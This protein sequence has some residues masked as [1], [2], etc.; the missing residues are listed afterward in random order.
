LLMAIGFLSGCSPTSR[1]VTSDRRYTGGFQAGQTYRLTDNASLILAAADHWQTGDRHYLTRPACADLLQREERPDDKPMATLPPGTRLRITRIIAF[2]TSP[3]PFYWHDL[4]H[5]LA[6]LL[7]GPYGGTEVDI[8]EIS[9]HV[10]ENGLTA[11]IA[12][13][14]PDCLQLEGK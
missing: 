3:T 5:P 1:D 6:T 7:D 13:P 4:I 2:H 11:I 10:F 14:S 12:E 8:T 9:H